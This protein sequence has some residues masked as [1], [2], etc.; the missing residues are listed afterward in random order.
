VEPIVV[1]GADRH[2]FL[3]AY[4]TCDVGA[5]AVGE[6]T[7]GFFTSPQGR[8]LADAVVAAT[9]E[10]LLAD[11]PTERAAAL[12]EHLSR[13]ILADRVTVGRAVGGVRWLALGPLAPE[14]LSRWVPELPIDLWAAGRGQVA[15]RE[16]S[17]R[18][19]RPLGEPVFSLRAAE[20]DASAVA[21]ALT[22]LG[23]AP[24]GF[25]ALEMLRVEAGI[26]RF[27]ADFDE[28]NFPQEVGFDDAVSYTKGCYLGQEVVARIHYR[29]HVNRELRALRIGGSDMPA[30]GA[31]LELDGEEVGRLGSVA[32]VSRASGASE[33]VGLALIHRKAATLGT[34]VSLPE[35]GVAQ[36]EAPGFS[37][38]AGSASA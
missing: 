27:G 9:D 28:A 37:L 5:L 23:C 22:A 24:V 16:V 12:V 36:V 8:V 25:D 31:P 29:G 10:A 6:G 26:P 11:V 14:V 34:R 30:P 13:Y 4:L 2:R 33:I 18:R 19:E 3:N 1:A 21:D 20:G 35:A 7:Y 38:T 32:R 15:G 17:V